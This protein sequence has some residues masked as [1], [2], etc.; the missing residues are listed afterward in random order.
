M[1]IFPPSEPD[2]YQLLKTLRG[3]QSYSRLK[4][5]VEAITFCRFSFQLSDLQELVESKRCH[6]VACKDPGGKLNQAEPL[7]VQ[8]VCRLHEV[9]E[10]GNIWDRAF[11]VLACFA[12]TLVR[13]GVIFAMAKLSDLTMQKMAE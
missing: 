8:D 13:G 1:D 2:F 11:C 6:G 3:T 4:S 7:T 12:Y 9:L 5:I 10:T